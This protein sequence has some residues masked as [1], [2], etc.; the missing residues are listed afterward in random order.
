[1]DRTCGLDRVAVS[2]RALAKLVPR[3]LGLAAASGRARRINLGRPRVTGALEQLDGFFLPFGHASGPHRFVDKRPH[4]DKLD[5]AFLEEW[6]WYL[7]SL[8]A[9]AL[10][11]WAL[12]W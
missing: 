9:L 7:H 10:G 2:S 11:S 6:C 3:S 5:R 1:M 8:A 4:R 12:S